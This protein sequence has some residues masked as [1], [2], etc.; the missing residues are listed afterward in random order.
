MDVVNLSL[1]ATFVMLVG[2]IIFFFKAINR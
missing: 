1:I 2:G